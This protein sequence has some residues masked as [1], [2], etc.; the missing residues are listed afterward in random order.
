MKN[1]ILLT[2]TRHSLP[3]MTNNNDHDDDIVSIIRNPMADQEDEEFA[4]NDSPVAFHYILSASGNLSAISSND[5]I[6][7]SMHLDDF[8]SQNSDVNVPSKEDRRM[9]EWFH[10]SYEE[11]GDHLITLSKSGAIICVSTDGSNAEL[12]GCFDYG[13]DCASW[14][15]DG[16]LLALVTFQPIT[17]EQD[18]NGIQ[19]EEGDIQSSSRIPVLMTMNTQFE[20]LSEVNLPPHISGE[21]VSICWNHKTDNQVVAIS[22]LDCQDKIRK[23]RIFKG[24]SLEHVATSRT[25]DGS[26]KMIPNILAHADIS[27]AGTNTS[28]LLACIQRKGR[29]GRNVVFLEPNGLQHGGF[30][31]E[32][33][34]DHEEVVRLDWNCE[35]D[36]LAVTLLGGADALDGSEQYGKVQFYHRNNYH[37]YLK[38]ETCLKQ[39]T[40]VSHVVFDNIKGY[41]VSICLQKSN[42]KF[43]PPQEWRHYKFCWDVSTTSQDGV[44]AVIDGSNVN[45]TM[46]C[47]A[48]IPP[49][50]YASR[51]TM[52]CAV[53]GVSHVPHHHS[54]LKCHG[55][56]LVAQMSD[57]S[58]ALCDVSGMSKTSDDVGNGASIIATVD[59][60]K[61]LNNLDNPSVE[62]VDSTCFRQFT[63]VDGKVDGDDIFV[64]IL[65]VACPEVLSNGQGLS[66][67]CDELVQLTVKVSTGQDVIQASVV[68]CNRI[69]LEGKV[70]R[71]VNWLNEIDREDEYNTM[72]RS[73]AIFELVDGSLFEYSLDLDGNT[74]GTIIPCEAE[75]MLLEP[76]PWITGLRSVED[77]KLIIGLS[78]RFRLYLGERQLCNASS[79]FFLSP[80]HGFLGY[81]TLG[82]RCQLRFLPLKVLLDFDP[83]MGS[84][85]DADTLSDGYEPRNVE[86]GSVLV[87][88]LPEKPQ[89]VLQLPRGNLEGVSPRAL[90]LPHIMSLIHNDQY[91]LALDMMRRQKV[92][93]NL[94][95]DMDPAKYLKGGGLRKLVGQV[96]AID[97]L[98]LFL[99]SLQDYDVTQWK[100]RIPSWLF[101]RDETEMNI[102]SRK[103]IDFS[104]KVNQVCTTI[105]NEM[106]QMQSDGS[107][108]PDHFFLPILSTFAK[109]NPPQLQNALE[110]IKEDA[111]LTVSKN[112][113]SKLKS[114]L[115]SDHAQSSITYLAFLADYELLFDTALGMYDFDLAKAVARNSQM[116]PKVYL[117][118]L[119]RL[120]NLPPYEAK[121][122]VDVKLKRYE[123]ALRNLYQLGV[124]EFDSGNT[125]EFSENHFDKCK[126]FIQEH[127]LY[128]LGLELFIGYPKWHRQIMLLLAEYL[129]VETKSELSLAIFLSA[130]P[131]CL[132]GA[133]RAARMCGDYK[134][135]FSCFD[136]I[137]TQS[138][139]FHTLA[140]EVAHEVADG[141]GGVLSKRE[142]FAAGA[143][144]LTDYCN[145]VE[146]AVDMLISAQ[147]WFEARRLA[148]LHGEAEIEKHIVDSALAYAKT[149]LLDF[150]SKA[151][152]FVEANKRYAEVLVI[153]RKARIEGFAPGEE[154]KDETGSLFSMASNASNTSIRS[155]MSTSSVGSVT[156]MSSVISAGAASTFHLI[157]N[158]ASIRHKS[159]F[160]NIGQKKKKKKTSRKERLG[161]KP[162][163]EEEL[164]SLQSRLK[165]NVADQ[166]LSDIVSETIRFL[167]QVGKVSVAME[168]YNGYESFKTLVDQN[169]RERIEKDDQTFQEEQQKARR[170]GQ[171]YER[172]TLDCEAEINSL[173]CTDLPKL[174][175][176]LFEYRIDY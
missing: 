35:S 87:S 17:H 126:N 149:C 83:L 174:I 143:K 99:A 81:V 12:I 22:T 161:L 30:K 111:I 115:L 107:C 86:R 48:M 165:E 173:R 125:A 152:A 97:H 132:E 14:S 110:L 167:S 9:N 63:V 98:N 106:M 168:V 1:L 53:I 140:H 127:K 88:I 77:Q 55:I 76:C 145:D 105:R 11:T 78:S 176:D 128:Q 139:D 26:G 112:S 104:T 82:S 151:E 42:D 146:G 29:A 36:L 66:R 5:R 158:E 85:A 129:L 90:V 80:S 134:T 47:K 61:E 114:I 119:K 27:W 60:S 100:Y 117:P 154:E 157:N 6:L 155:S 171:F 37:W 124:P 73:H 95:V 45:L 21:K 94:I 175:H 79:S 51:L 19:K 150:E 49:P 15:A 147:M 137:D 71:M 32:H 20:I 62:P 3:C 113:Q 93:M 123:S 159:K 2:E 166:E 120:R 91:H 75:P 41:D 122:E 170:D 65:C 169:Q 31:L 144:I 118:M 57:G 4:D 70:L 28:N 10:L 8:I 24:E 162:G 116:D 18:D 67:R 138:E 23:I 25:E 156:S 133:R 39:G 148:R 56:D 108:S 84:D 43:T 68:Q 52:G 38:Y 33:R 46:F 153:R 101:S 40:K 164:I 131:P 141:R 64:Q 54:H 69:V 50:M 34:L 103:S 7:W 72:S 172:V 130:K 44:A 109:Q 135:F 16:E 142:S 96:T 136:S 121:Y 59:L 163:T 92:D 89:V 74:A 13:I 58:I 160:N 102:E